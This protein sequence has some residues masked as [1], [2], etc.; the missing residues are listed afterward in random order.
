M[1]QNGHKTIKK[2][3][4]CEQPH[5]TMGGLA[6][7]QPPSWLVQ[8]LVQGNCP[9]HTPFCVTGAVGIG[10]GSLAGGCNHCLPPVLSVAKGAEK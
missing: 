5:R 2:K 3:S 8:S 7:L 1:E 4:L 10:K 6:F 9:F